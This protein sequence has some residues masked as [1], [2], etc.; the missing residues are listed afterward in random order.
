MKKDEIVLMGTSLVTLV[1]NILIFAILWD[2][3]KVLEK[4]Q[5]VKQI[6]KKA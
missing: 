2:K 6:F 4:W 3:E 1:L 5:K